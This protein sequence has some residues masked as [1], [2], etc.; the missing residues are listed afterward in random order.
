MK[1]MCDSAKRVGVALELTADLP[2]PDVMERWYGEPI[3]CCYLPT[4]IFLTNRKG[5]PVLSRVHQQVLLRLFKVSGPDKTYRFDM[6][7]R[8]SMDTACSSP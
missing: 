2:S 6:Y 4:S 5:F 1:T 8:Y 7:P 3:K